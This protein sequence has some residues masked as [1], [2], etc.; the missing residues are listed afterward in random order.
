MSTIKFGGSNWPWQCIWDTTTAYVN[1]PGPD[2]QGG[3]RMVA[4]YWANPP[5]YTC[6]KNHCKRVYK[7]GKLKTF[8]NYWTGG[9][10]PYRNA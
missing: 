7:D 10:V 6:P 3:C 5:F 2:C 4:N 1:I 9:V 8:R